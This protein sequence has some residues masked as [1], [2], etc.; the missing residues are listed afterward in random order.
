[1]NACLYK[2]LTG[3][4]GYE[5]LKIL[6]KQSFYSANYNITDE[7][8]NFSSVV[9]IDIA[10]PLALSVN[11]FAVLLSYSG[12]LSC[13]NLNSNT[14]VVQDTNSVVSVPLTGTITVAASGFS[15]FPIATVV[16]FDLH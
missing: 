13:K 12:V 9:Q 6:L 7:T 14:F 4:D 11:Q 2:D 10:T 15:T 8:I 3:F 1:M 5:G 16:V